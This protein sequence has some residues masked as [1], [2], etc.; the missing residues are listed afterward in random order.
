MCLADCDQRKIGEAA[1]RVTQNLGELVL[2]A[3]ATLAF[4]ATGGN[5]DGEMAREV[6]AEIEKAS[7][8]LR[9]QTQALLTKSESP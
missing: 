5:D 2:Y 4:Y 1:V 7:G 9:G 6:L 8:N 3:T